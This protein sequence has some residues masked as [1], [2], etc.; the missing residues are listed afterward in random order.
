MSRGSH[1][2]VWLRTLFDF[3]DLLVRMTVA[4]CMLPFVALMRQHMVNATVDAAAAC[5]RTR[6]RAH[7]AFV[8]ISCSRGI[9][10]V[11]FPLKSRAWAF[12]FACARPTSQ[13][14]F[15]RVT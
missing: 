5:T 11:A 1:G 7:V 12:H 4:L 10:G 13:K 14:R 2:T 8:E 9:R 6:A 15:V 3:A